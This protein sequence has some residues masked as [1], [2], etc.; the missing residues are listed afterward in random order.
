[1]C[2]RQ[3]WVTTLADSGSGSF[4]WA[5]ESAT[6][7]RNRISFRVHGRIVLQSSLPDIKRCL[8]INGDNETLPVVEIDCNGH[9]GLLVTRCG[10]NS[11]IS[12]LTVINASSAGI[13]LKNANHVTIRG[14]YVGVCI[15]G[16]PSGNDGSGIWILDGKENCIGQNP[17]LISGFASNVISANR[18]DGILIEGQWSTG[19]R[20]SSNFIG[21]QPSGMVSSNYGYGNSNG[22]LIK[23]GASD[24]IIGGRAFRNAA[25]ETNDPTGS[26][27]TSAPVTIF[28]PMGNLISG[29][30]C[31]GV[32]I[33]G[34]A[35]NALSGNFVG[36]DVTG[37]VAIGNGE[38]GISVLDGATD[39][40]ILGC[41]FVTNPF[42]FYNVISGNAEHGIWVRDAHGTTIQGNFCGIGMNNATVVANGGN[43]ILIAGTS[44]DT[45]VGGVIPLGNVCS[46]NGAN[47][48]KV[49]DEASSFVSFNTF[50]GLFAFGGAAPN[51]ID[52]I[53]LS[54]VAPGNVVRTCVLSG[55]IG[56]G[57]TLDGAIGAIAES[58][59]VGLN[60]SG[61]APLPN[62]GHGVVLSGIA[63][64]NAVGGQISSVIPR[65]TISSNG[66][67]GIVLQDDA[68]LNAITLN[69]VGL[70]VS[71]IN[72]MGNG[73]GGIWLKDRAN[74]NYIGPKEVVVP[75]KTTNYV[76]ASETGPGIQIDAM[77]FQNIV[78]ENHVGLNIKEE[79]LPNAA[80]GIIDVTLPGTNHIFN[81]FNQ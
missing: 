52:G 25:G 81:N 64:N 7:Q 71:G 15:D 45:T 6:Q 16:T 63:A 50:A 35:K 61:N 31:D 44:R 55:N 68:S 36:T 11:V 1:M 30:R 74:N 42:V 33:V 22:I 46:G 69:L 54:S 67:W 73:Q 29:N 49:T 79:P 37:N 53:R 57:L 20:I 59:I 41:Q 51:G 8:Y 78:T 47:G 24:N 27:G 66:G 18:G 75:K 48:I 17:T 23:D 80:G 32:R 38:S 77:C 28:P 26:V 62:G 5:I 76:S 34:T 3:L 14:C 10:S 13:M 43:G 39:T 58:I 65:N 9:R 56:N 72:A 70:D 19:N 12:G 21:I 60:T 40:A 4:R 2:Q